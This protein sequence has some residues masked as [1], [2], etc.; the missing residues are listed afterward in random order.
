LVPW[1]A[2]VHHIQTQGL[3]WGLNDETLYPVKTRG[4][5]NEMTADAA[6][7]SIGSGLL[8]IIHKRKD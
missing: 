2:P 8:L 7:I 6:S 5:S 3:R 1:G 4:I